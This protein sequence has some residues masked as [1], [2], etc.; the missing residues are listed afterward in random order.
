MI[1]I[2]TEQMTDEKVIADECFARETS[3][4]LIRLKQ[5]HFIILFPISTTKIQ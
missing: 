4:R 1:M 5:L 3:N 2:K